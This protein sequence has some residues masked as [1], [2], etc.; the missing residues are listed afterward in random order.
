M[1]KGFRP[2]LEPPSHRRAVVEARRPVLCALLTAVVI[3]LVFTIFSVSGWN[4]FVHRFNA[5]QL[6]FHVTDEVSLSEV[7]DDLS[8]TFCDGYKVTLSGAGQVFLLP[9]QPSVNVTTFD[10]VPVELKQLPN[11]AFNVKDAYLLAG[12][13]IDL[14]AC[15]E[16]GSPPF[17]ASAVLIQGDD[18]FRSWRQNNYCD[19]VLE[20]VHIPDNVFC[21]SPIQR[22]E[23]TSAAKLYH[24]VRT[25]ERYYM[26]IFYGRPQMNHRENE[27]K[28]IRLQGV[29][30]RTHYITSNAERECNLFHQGSCSF[31][32]PWMSSKDIVV[33]FTGFPLNPMPVFMETRCN[34]RVIFWIC[35]FGLVPVL[36]V[37]PVSLM[38]GWFFLRRTK[39]NAKALRLREERRRLAAE[40]LT[41]SKSGHT[42]NVAVHNEDYGSMAIQFG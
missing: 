18:N 11:R 17:Y 38:F 27:E 8:A 39:R 34:T 3:L 40:K 10:E 37:I 30:K 31:E 23:A 7:N 32:L 12:S 15:R 6:V 42:N 1:R 33:K 14:T 20:R 36:C 19:C 26:V 16:P 13:V 5:T 21:G 24:K 28:G 29:F 2:T 22:H 41:A 25:N 4:V 35:L 9:K